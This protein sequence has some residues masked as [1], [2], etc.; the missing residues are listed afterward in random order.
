MCGE[1]C[2]CD[3][4]LPSGWGSSPRV[5]GAPGQITAQ[6][7]A[8][9]IIPA[10]AGSTR[11]P[12]P[13]APCRGNHPRVCGEQRASLE[14]DVSTAGSSPRVRGAHGAHRSRRERR[15]IIPA[16][17]GSTTSPT[18]TTSCGRDH[19]RVC[20]EHQGAATAA[21]ADVGSSPR[22][23]GARVA[24]RLDAEVPGIIPACAGSTVAHEKHDR[25]DGDHPRVCGEHDQMRLL[26]HAG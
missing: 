26:V 14:P 3:C 21:V 15:G 24:R 6:Q 10:C 4:S 11:Y 1:H 12:T 2:A 22:V 7:A 19:P 16:C 17:A 8:Q 13:S 5:R 23:R 25:I 9:G 18:R 20:G